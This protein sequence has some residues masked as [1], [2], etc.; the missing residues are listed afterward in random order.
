MVGGGTNQTLDKDVKTGF[1]YN[2]GGKHWNS[3]TQR[4][5]HVDSSTMKPRALLGTQNTVS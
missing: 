1:I 2:V 5:V 3:H 4:Q